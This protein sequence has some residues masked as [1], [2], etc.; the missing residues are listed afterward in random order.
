MINNYL[1]II[2]I[3]LGMLILGCLVFIVIEQIV[4]DCDKENKDNGDDNDGSK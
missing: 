4:D 3:V 2:S 1:I